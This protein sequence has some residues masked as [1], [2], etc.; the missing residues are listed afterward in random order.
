MHEAIAK[1]LIQMKLRKIQ[2]LIS[3]ILILESILGGLLYFCTKTA[4]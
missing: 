2:N 3:T 4:I 1:L